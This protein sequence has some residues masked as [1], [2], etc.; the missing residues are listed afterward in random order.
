MTNLLMSLTLVAASVGVVAVS[1]ALIWCW[2]NHCQ[3][4][5]WKF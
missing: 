2:M 4:R 3:L 5:N 1:G